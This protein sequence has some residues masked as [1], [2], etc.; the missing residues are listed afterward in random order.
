MFFG[1]GRLAGMRR[2]I[3]VGRLKYCN[4]LHYTRFEKQ[5]YSMIK[6]TKK[7]DLHV[8][9]NFIKI[10]MTKKLMIYNG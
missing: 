7:K 2:D 3:K 6:I 8:F 1:G 10:K 4:W 9:S 5:I